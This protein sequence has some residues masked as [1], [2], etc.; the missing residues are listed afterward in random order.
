MGI[1][2]HIDP[3]GRTDR[4]TYRRVTF[5]ALVGMLALMFRHSWLPE[6]AVFLTAFGVV[7]MLAYVVFWCITVRRL[8]ACGESTLFGWCFVFGGAVI[9]IFIGCRFPDLDPDE[10]A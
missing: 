5:A 2:D 1:W 4:E 6:G 10:A 7:A 3:G 9:P 8:R